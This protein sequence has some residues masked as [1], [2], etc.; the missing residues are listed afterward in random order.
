MLHP[1]EKG[2]GKD[3]PNVLDFNSCTSYIGNL[4]AMFTNKLGERNPPIIFHKEPWSK[5]LGAIM[6]MKTY[7]FRKHG[8]KIINPKQQANK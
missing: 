8:I 1:S 5:I 6:D 3:L 4:K 2:N 7:Y